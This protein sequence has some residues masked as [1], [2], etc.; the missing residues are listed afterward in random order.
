MSLV[1]LSLLYDY[2]FWFSSL[3]NPQVHVSFNHVK[4]LERHWRKLVSHPPFQ[5]SKMILLQIRKENLILHQDTLYNRSQSIFICLKMLLFKYIVRKY[6]KIIL[7]GHDV[8][9]SP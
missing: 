9:T 7:I 2:I 6:P 5:L 1:Y 8:S 3:N 4:E